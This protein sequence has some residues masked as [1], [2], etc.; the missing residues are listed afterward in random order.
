MSDNRLGH[1]KILSKTEVEIGDAVYNEATLRAT[2]KHMS[3]FK[4]PVV[5]KVGD[6]VMIKPRVCHYYSDRYGKI[7][8]VEPGEFVSVEFSR[9]ESYMGSCEGQTKKGHGL[10]IRKSVLQ[11]QEG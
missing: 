2:L 9:Y 1:I 3:E 7:L 5:F 8:H 6:F 10:F 11:H 4:P